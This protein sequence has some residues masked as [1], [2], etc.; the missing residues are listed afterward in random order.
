MLRQ[1]ITRAA[2]WIWATILGKVATGIYAYIV[3][4]L[5]LGMVTSL[6]VPLMVNIASMGVYSD[7]QGFVT[8]AV[9]VRSVQRTFALKEDNL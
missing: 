7:V 8:G 1:R 9:L 4:G 6:E 3:P 2:G 5:M